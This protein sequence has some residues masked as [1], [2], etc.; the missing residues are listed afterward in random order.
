MSLLKRLVLA[1][2][3]LGVGLLSSD[4]KAGLI[5]TTAEIIPPSSNIVP[6]PPGGFLASSPIQVQLYFEFSL[7]ASEPA[8]IAFDFDWN[9]FDLKPDGTHGIIIARE[10]TASNGIPISPGETVGVFGLTVPLDGPD[11]NAILSPGQTELHLGVEVTRAGPIS[12]A[13]EPSSVALACGVVPFALTF[14]WKSRRKSA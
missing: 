5:V 13:P 11:I 3:L 1:A 12:T 6:V 10:H 7:P 8:P 4:A 14:A 2:G 9:I